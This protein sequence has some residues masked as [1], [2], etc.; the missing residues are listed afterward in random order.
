LYYLTDRYGNP[1]IPSDY[2]YLPKIEAGDEL[3]ILL[4]NYPE[5]D[6]NQRLFWKIYNESSIQ[7]FVETLAKIIH[8]MHPDNYYAVE[9][10]LLGLYFPGEVTSFYYDNE[11]RDFVASRIE[12]DLFN[13]KT[14]ITGREVKYEVLTDISY[15]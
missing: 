1:K 11:P 8:Q 9:G 14:T 7:N 15:E 13:S 6:L 4:S 10:M 3:T 2:S 5:E 12:I